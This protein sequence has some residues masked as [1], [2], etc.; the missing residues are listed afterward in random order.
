MVL[1]LAVVDGVVYVGSYD[2]DL[3]AFDAT[4]TVDCS[5][6]PE[7]CAPLWTAPTGGIVVSSPV[8][9]DGVVYVGS[10]DHDLYA[11][12]ATGTVDCSGTPKVVPRR[13]PPPLGASWPRRRRWPTGWSTSVPSTTISMPSTPTAPPGCS[14]TPKVCAPLWTAPIGG[15]V[16][17]LWRVA[18]GVVYVGSFDHDL[19]AFDADG[20]TGV[21]GHAQGV[22]PV[23][24]GRDR[25]PHTVVAGRP[26]WIR[27][28][29][30]L[31]LQLL[32]LRAPVDP[33]TR[34]RLRP[35]GAMTTSRPPGGRAARAPAAQGA[36]GR[37]TSPTTGCPVPTRGWGTG[38]H[39]AP[40]G[41]NRFG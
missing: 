39:P 13:G 17:L 3:Y 6:S 15:I 23:V 21:F 7:V 2:H 9:A 24:D 19:Y 32:R 35:I 29:G 41:R 26:L 25:G 4:G 30:I 22:C 16:A 40:M 12:D 14:G 18:N 28:R 31:R 27:L 36:S 38:G 11:F 1:L 5:G 37:L 8:V 34:A 20:T 10:Y 33:A